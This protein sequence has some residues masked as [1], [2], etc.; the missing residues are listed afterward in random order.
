MIHKINTVLEKQSLLEQCILNTNKKLDFLVR[1]MNPQEAIRSSTT[2]QPT[3]AEMAKTN[4]GQPMKTTTTLPA[5]PATIVH[6][7]RVNKF[8]KFGVTI[9]TKFRQPK[10]V[11][12]KNSLKI[13]NAIKS[14]LLKIN[15]KTM[16]TPIQ[17]KAVT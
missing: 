2:K 15:A 16:D 13:M 3:F 17:I 5:K 9:R 10:P 14:A 1:Q 4:M 8:K 12:Q 7:T 6:P 11:Q